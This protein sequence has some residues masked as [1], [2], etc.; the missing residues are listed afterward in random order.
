VH[1]K[2]NYVWLEP[3]FFT[4]LGTSRVLSCF[5]ERKLSE[6]LRRVIYVSEKVGSSERDV[7]DIIN[8]SAR[9]NP[10]KEITG[11]LLE[12]QNSF[13]QIL[14]GPS[15]AIQTLYK[16]ISEDS[17]HTNVKSLC[18]EPLE[19]RLFSDWSMRR[20]NYNHMEWS[21]AAF[22]AGNFLSISVDTAK[23]IFTRISEQGQSLM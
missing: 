2:F 11:C 12:G 17:R 16:T 5:V 18:N 3:N 7:T 8:A 23:N 19:T 4:N 21:D 1:H 22:N 20:D 9:N 13:L 10:S 14:E 6:Q 15:N